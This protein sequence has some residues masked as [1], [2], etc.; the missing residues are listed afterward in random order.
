MTR[1]TREPPGFSD[2][3]AARGPS[4]VRTAT[5]LTH[6]HAAAEDLVQT[7][8]AKAWPKW[9]RTEQHEAYVRKIIVHEFARGW[10]RKW[11]GEIA[12]ETL[13]ERPH[14]DGTDTVAAREDL[15]RALAG[16]PRKQR[17]VIVLRYFHDYSEADIAAALGI[18][19]GTVKSHA[20]RGLAA[21]RVSSDI[22]DRAERQS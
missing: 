15:M 5:L 7:A 16:L 10:R 19:T 4:L 6:D 20:S 11:R 21:L 22:A 18:S 17:A 8:L 12:T 3:V 14:P 1:G 13:P 2:F 9:E